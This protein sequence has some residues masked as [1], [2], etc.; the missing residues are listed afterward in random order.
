EYPAGSDD[1]VRIADR[2][3]GTRGINARRLMGA[4]FVPE[5]RHGHAAVSALSL[6]DN[7]VLARSQSDRRAFLGG[8]AL[9][10]IRQDAVKRA[11]KR[12]SEAM[13][14]RKSGE[15]PPA[16]SLS[17]GNLQKFIVGR[18]LD[19]QPTVLVVNQPTWGVDAGA[20]SR[21]RQALVD[22]AKSGSAV[23]VISQDLDEIFE[24]ATEIAVISEG[25]LSDIYPAAELSREKIGLLMGG[26]YG[27]TE[28]AETAHAH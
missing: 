8:G 2:P 26:M 18:E 15:N 21:I 6:S 27:K 23:L 5:E 24:V 3:V 16:G 4:G 17:G 28:T 7:L 22:L 1:A 9:G 19:R 12:I 11:T 13:D 14:V 10:L 25:R 20:A